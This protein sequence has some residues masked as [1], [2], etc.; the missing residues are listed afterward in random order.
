[1]I[2][3]NGVCVPAKLIQQLEAISSD[4]ESDRA[5]VNNIFHIIF[6]ETFIME[7]MEK[8]LSRENV[9]SEF[10]DSDRYEILKSIFH[11]VMTNL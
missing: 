4:P 1:M 10:R 7:R 9:L 8:G 2:Y 5:Y 3:A 11:F 6:P